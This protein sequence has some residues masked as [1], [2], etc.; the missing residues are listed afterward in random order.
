MLDI[1]RSNAQSLWVK[2]AFGV[3]I[4]VFVFWGI[5]SFT[6]TGSTNVIGTVN[7]EPI[8]YQQFEMAYRNA[9]ENYARQANN[10]SLSPEEKTML[11][12]QVFQQL[13]T[14]TLIGQ[15]AKR[16]NMGVSPYELRLY[17]G[18]LEIFQNEK[19]EFDPERYTNILASRRQT[20]AQFEADISRRLLQEKMV[21]FVSS[22]SW[23][24]GLEARAR[25]NF[26]R[27]KRVL[28]Y[29]YL[30]ADAA[31]MAETQVTDEQ[32]SKYYEDHKL[33]YSI[34]QKAN[35][36]YIEVN[37]LE[38]VSPG[39]V[40]DEEA[41]AW[42][43]KNRER[44]VEP[45]S[46]EAS[47]IL[48]PLD[49]DADEAAVKAAEEKMAAIQ[50]ELADGKPFAE[51]ANEHN[52]PNAAGEDGK[53]GRITRGMTVQA[54][55]NAAFA[56]EV[57]KLTGP[58]R[59]EFGLHLILVTD[60]KP[61]SRKSFNEVKDEAKK[62]VA[63][64]RGRERLNDVMDALVEDNILGKDMAESAK[65]NNLEARTTGLKNREE[66]VQALGV[67]ADGASAILSRGANQPVDVPLEAGD[68]YVI[69]RV[70]EASPSSFSPLEDVKDDVVARIRETVGL[71]AAMKKLQDVLS[72]VQKGGGKELPAEWADRMRTS[73][74]VDRDQV[75]K[76][77]NDQPELATAIFQ[78]VPG[79]WLSGVFAV[80]DKDSKGA[81]IARVKRVVDPAETEWQQ[82]EG[83][84]VNLTTRERQDGIFQAFMEDLAGRSKVLVRNQAVIDRQNM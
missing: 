80:S 56:A 63:A 43:E 66:I 79:S 37:P 71:E 59:S 11:G 41:M 72:E 17:V 53:V 4:L 9:E 78:T 61:E 18:S 24:D 48:V 19:G 20:P 47:H 58:V 75:M 82:F 55:D 8:T 22:G 34:P 44:F 51:A 49:L 12:R 77:F 23:S 74:P 28:D 13:V 15:E 32:V 46:V 50:K 65:A 16:N 54:F 84:M 5:G 39:S 29:V 52:P 81:L 3:I 14:E 1:I 31:L 76:P 62:A 42:Y 69:V 7:D 33:D 83:I 25:F 36:Q 57:G 21:A 40:S 2:V 10:R 68:K 26:L 30:P 6:D 35:V 38:I 60:R 70:L 64:E 73:D 27:Q 67:T 45:E